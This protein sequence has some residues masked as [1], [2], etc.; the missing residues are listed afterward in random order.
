MGLG[1]RAATSTSPGR[2]GP[3]QLREGEGAGCGEGG[4]F[5]H[6]LGRETTGPASC[7][8]F[9]LLKSLLLLHLE[10]I[11][12]EEILAEESPFHPQL[13]LGGTKQS[14]LAGKPP[15]SSLG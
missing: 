5:G 7:A 1:T 10:V 13:L 4:E 9:S 6:T 8:Q 11:V 2:L 3:G 14:F 15:T 12:Q